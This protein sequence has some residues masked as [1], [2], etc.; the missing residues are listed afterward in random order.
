MSVDSSWYTDTS[1]SI[2]DVWPNYCRN[3]NNYNLRGCT[4]PQSRNYQS[5]ITHQQF[6]C[7]HFNL[8]LT[9]EVTPITPKK[10]IKILKMRCRYCDFYNVASEVC[11]NAAS[12]HYK[13]KICSRQ[14]IETHGYNGCSL[15]K[16][17]PIEDV[18]VKSSVRL[19]MIL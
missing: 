10:K 19:L 15:F 12:Q 9:V 5:V 7:S 6:A 17:Y 4:N 13:L 8:G 1:T 3:C 14:H 2:S 16:P 11:S 18:V